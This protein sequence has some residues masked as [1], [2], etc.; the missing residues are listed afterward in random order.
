MMTVVMIKMVLTTQKE[1]RRM[2][3]SL[4]KQ[5][6]RDLELPVAGRKDELIDCLLGQGKAG[7]K[8][9][10]WKNP[11]PKASCPNWLPMH[12]QEFVR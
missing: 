6:L 9:K 8:V 3:C 12:L 11:K 1:M 7:G 2:A 10:E 5:C 4:E